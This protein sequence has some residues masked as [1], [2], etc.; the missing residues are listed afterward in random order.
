MASGKRERRINY[1][2]DKELRK[3]KRRELLQM[4]LVQCEETERLQQEANEMQTQIEAVME[5]YERLKKKLDIKDERLNQKDA[6]IEE[7]SRELEELKTSGKTGF[8][9]AG[10]VA[11]AA[12]KLSAVMEEV[13]KAAE[14]YLINARKHPFGMGR[15]A[16]VRRKQGVSTGQ[17]VPMSFSQSGKTERGMA[18]GDFYG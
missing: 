8:E 5:S 1:M 6:Q 15:A 3:L 9:E 2:A 13:Q 11:E 14:Q 18:S 10:S 4:L 12:V 17:V 7:L 16:G